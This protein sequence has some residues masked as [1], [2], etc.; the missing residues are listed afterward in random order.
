VAVVIAYLQGGPCD[1]TTRTVT[2]AEL[3]ANLLLCK[4]G[5]YANIPPHDHHDGHPVWIYIGRNPTDKPPPKLKATQALGGW[6]AL[7]K[8]I[9][10]G[11]PAALTYSQHVTSKSLHTLARAR[12]VRI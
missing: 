12:K 7:R 4:G 1:G 6:A 8:S 3:D 10:R 9:N 11:M 5:N 2:A